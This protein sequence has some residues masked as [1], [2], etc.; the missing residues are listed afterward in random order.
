MTK[1]KLMKKNDYCY[2]CVAVSSTGQEHICGFS[3]TFA[4]LKNI[5][6]DYIG[7]CKDE[8]IEGMSFSAPER[9]SR[10][11]IID[12]FTGLKEKHIKWAYLL[13]GFIKGEDKMFLNTPD[14]IDSFLCLKELYT[15][16]ID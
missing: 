15:D 9:W 14:D 8:N 1:K 10:K 2:A 6:E 5:K 13:H 12:F 7:A 16:E 4:G 11:D 3:K